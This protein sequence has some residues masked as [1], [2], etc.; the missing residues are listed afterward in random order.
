MRMWM[1]DPRKMCRQHLL[2]EH[3]EL[4]ML[5]GSLR[6]GK[7]LAGF[8]ANGL[9]E[10]HSVRARH[11]Q[12]VRE[13]RRRGYRHRSPLPR[14]T[15]RKLGRVVRKKSLADLLAR[16]HACRTLFVPAR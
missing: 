15:A 13:M 7:S 9:I 5:V 2:G 14:F 6:K 16:C 12:L 4:H 3:V 8:L 10:V 11:A 1:V